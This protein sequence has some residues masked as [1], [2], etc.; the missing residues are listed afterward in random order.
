[1]CEAEI[2]TEKVA[3]PFPPSLVLP[4]TPSPDLSVSLSL[5]YLGGFETWEGLE[6]I[7]KLTV[8]RVHVQ[9]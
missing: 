3:V 6:E 8:L 5:S 7:V 9:K 1:M 4:S 2:E